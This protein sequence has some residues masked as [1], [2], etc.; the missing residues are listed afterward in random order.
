MTAADMHGSQAT[1]PLARGRLAWKRHLARPSRCTLRSSLGPR[2]PSRSPG[3][4]KP[5][6]GA[7]TRPF[8]CAS[9]GRRSEPSTATCRGKPRCCFCVSCVH[10]IRRPGAAWGARIA[11]LE[12]TPERPGS[13]LRQ[14]RSGA[15][16]SPRRPRA[17]FFRMRHDPG[18][19]GA[20]AM[21]IALRLWPRP[22]G[23]PA[24]NSWAER[25]GSGDAKLLNRRSGASASRILGMASAGFGPLWA[26][27]RAATF[28]RMR[29][30]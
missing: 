23:A 8:R 24:L 13:E 30:W 19:R 4:F 17:V 1:A 2:D 14:R 27:L 10:P 20:F 28:E 5:P 3:P 29:P 21:S 15:Q 16:H 7:P 6:R 9:S 26:E 11:C 12:R 25:A 18:G 22:L